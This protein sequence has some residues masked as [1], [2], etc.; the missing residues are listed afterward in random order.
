MIKVHTRFIIVASIGILA[1]IGL[2]GLTTPLYA[3]DSVFAT[4]TPVQG[5]AT[6]TPESNQPVATAPMI[7]TNT[8]EPSPT[9]I[10]PA[11]GL[12]NYALRLWLEGDMLEV[13][14]DQI[15]LIDADNIDSQRA[16]QLIQYELEFRFAGAP[17]NIEDRATVVKAMLDAPIGTIDMQSVVRPYI[18]YAINNDLIEAGQFEGFTVEVMPANLDAGN[19]D[20]AVIHILYPDPL[21]DAVR[22]DDYV[23]AVGDADGGYRF[24]PSEFIPP[25]VPYNGIQGIEMERL[26]DVNF[27]GVDELALIVDDGDLNKRLYILAYRGGQAVDITRS[28]ETLRFGELV[29]WNTDEED[30][31]VSESPIETKLYQLASDQWFCISELEITWQYEGNFYRPTVAVNEGFDNQDTFGCVISEAD[32]L[33]SMKPISATQLITDELVKYGSN[34]VRTDRA[35]MTLAMLYALDGQVELARETAIAAQA[36]NNDIES[37][38]GLQSEM[39]L[40]MLNQ[41]ENTAFD[42]CVAL[43]EA[44]HGEVGACDVK[45]LLGRVFAEATFSD[46]E[47]IATQL[48]RVGLNVVQSQVISEVGRADRTAV[49]FGILSAGWWAFVVNDGDYTAMP[50]DTPSEFEIVDPLPSMITIPQTVYA[51]LLSDNDPAGVLNIIETTRV[52]NPNIPFSEAFRF[53]EALSNDLLNNREVARVTYYDVWDDYPESLWGRMASKHLELR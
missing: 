52:A 34:V 26:T 30:E 46:N 45:A 13:L 23:L 4:N 48:E 43:A 41:P 29:A 14:L 5:F 27:D 24:A 19:V 2:I 44:D 22:Y 7:A 37:W 20:D 28:G 15:A 18:E 16:V 49:D 12:S 33:F 3:Q 8:P 35:V 32:S 47:P 38:V 31:D 17:H 25:I 1:L 9:P 53:I 50:I 11:A 6:N 51:A 39:F 36:I 21:I 40:Q 10:G 42:I